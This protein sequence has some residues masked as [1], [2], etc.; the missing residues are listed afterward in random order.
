MASISDAEHRGESTDVDNRILGAAESCVQDVGLERVT[1]AQVARRARVSRPTIYRRWPG[2]HS[3]LSAMFARRVI[4]IVQEVAAGG[5]DR[6]A[7]VEQTVAALARMRHDPLVSAVLLAPPALVMRYISERLSQGHMQLVDIMAE[8]LKAAQDG[9]TVRAGD[10]RQMAAVM[11]LIV[12]TGVVS[13]RMVDP[14]LDEAA[15]DAEL[16]LVLDRYLS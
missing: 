2:I 7:I 4:T 12:Q 9:G 10:S 13:A 8:D 11:V 6:H 1:M 15:L 14:I 3:L 5:A 16:T